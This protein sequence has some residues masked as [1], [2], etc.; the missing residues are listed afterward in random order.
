[1]L[2][3]QV[4]Q[5]ATRGLEHR[6]N[7][8][9]GLFRLRKGARVKHSNPKRVLNWEFPASLLQLSPLQCYLLSSDIAVEVVRPIGTEALSNAVVLPLLASMKAINTCAL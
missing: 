5:R 6:S 2:T 9:Q 1:M 8:Q 3:N 4:P 7:E